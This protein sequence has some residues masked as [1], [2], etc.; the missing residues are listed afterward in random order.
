LG[1]AST[2]AGCLFP[3]K[4]ATCAMRAFALP[5]PATPLPILFNKLHTKSCHRRD[6]CCVARMS[7]EI[8]PCKYSCFPDWCIITF[9]R[10]RF[11]GSVASIRSAHCQCACIL[12]WETLLTFLSARG[13]PVTRRGT[14]NVPCHHLCCIWE[15]SSPILCVILCVVADVYSACQACMLCLG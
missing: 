15:S 8:L 7:T 2:L 13:P 14:V 11:P 9:N 1:H 6:L 4:S 5:L 3:D 12:M 10:C